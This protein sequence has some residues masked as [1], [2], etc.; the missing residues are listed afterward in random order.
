MKVKYTDV[1]E[2]VPDGR[3]WLDT[4]LPSPPT[5]VYPFIL[6]GNSVLDISQGNA[7][8]KLGKTQRRVGG[9]FHVSHRRVVSDVL[10]PYT[11]ATDKAPNGS[12]LR[13]RY[14]G[15]LAALNGDVDAPQWPW[16]GRHSATSAE[17]DAF[18]ATAI[19]RV[20][21]TNPLSGLT[22]A[23]VELRRE[24]LP[25]V[26]GIQALKSKSLAGKSLGSEYLNKEFGWDP[27]ISDLRKFSQV[28]QNHDKL[29]QQYER[30][31]GKLLRRS[32]G[33]IETTS[34]TYT[35]GKSYTDSG[36]YPLN[37]GTWL[38]E[39]PNWSR[40]ITSTEKWWFEGVF[41][42]YLPSFDPNGSNFERNRRIA[43]KLYGTGI[44][45][46]LIWNLTP[47]TWA[48]DWF[49]NFGD[50]FHNIGAF[51]DNG[52]VMPW[53]YVMVEKTDTITH[54]IWGIRTKQS[55]YQGGDSSAPQNMSCSTVL[56]TITRQRKTATPYGFGL[57]FDGFNPFQLSILSALGLSRR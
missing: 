12:N 45:P 9:D 51:A 2:S 56:E 49:G 18:G 16:H 25:S 39:P 35:S 38:I 47:W 30:G 1:R 41:T 48:A 7:F 22:N 29:V 13:R 11:Y 43:N 27:L 33:P 6:R 54:H 17:M 8:R 44:T 21:P 4:N 15:Q 37:S 3:Y 14:R 24:G 57:T 34:T 50:V 26:P 46:E 10:T 32:Y 52:L 36:L 31:S 40:T 20:E 19:S 23:L 53:G 28:V 42:Y 5:T 55:E